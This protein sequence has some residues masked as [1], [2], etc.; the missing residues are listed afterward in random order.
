MK[1]PEVSIITANY[2]C[3]SFIAETIKSIQAQ[4]FKDWELIIIDD[5]SSD[6]GLDIVQSYMK[7][8]ERIIL[9]QNET[10]LG[11]A[12]TR[13]KG[14]KIARGRYISFLDSDDLWKEDKLSKQLSF[15]K[16]GEISFSYTSYALIDEDN[17]D[18]GEFLVRGKVSYSDLLKTCDIGCLTAM[19]DTEALDKT[20]MPDILKRQDYGLW[21]RLLKKTDYAYAIEEK[22]AVY[23]LRK[24]SIS[25]NKRRAAAYQWK[26]YR[27]VEEFSI[28]K[29]LYF[30]IHY[31]ING[32]LKYKK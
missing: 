24:N 28:V 31:A 10:N 3:E 16:S 32:F 17:V 8:D 29:S 2:N 18:Q 13:N 21:L 11:A 5:N 4:S 7:D 22:L 12:K 6:K 23:R 20:E 26:I 30:F 27:N 9:L 14:I 15:M 25:S 19:Y 1:I